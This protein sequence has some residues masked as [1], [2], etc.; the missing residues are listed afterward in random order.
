MAFGKNRSTPLVDSDETVVG[1]TQEQDFVDLEDDVQQTT[2]ATASGSQQENDP[3][4]P[5]L[6]E[7]TFIGAGNSKNPG[8]GKQ[9]VC[10][11]RKGT[12]TSSYTRIYAH[13]FGAPLDKKAEIKRCPTLIRDR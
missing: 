6:N 8:G 10:K 12:Y 3:S 1:E 11:H 9:W 2:R 4:K 5:L 7:V 13:F